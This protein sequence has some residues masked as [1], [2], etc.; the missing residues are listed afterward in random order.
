MPVTIDGTNGISTPG[1]STGGANANLN[2][3]FTSSIDSDGT[4]STG[5][6]TPVLAPSNWKYVLN[7]GAFTIAAPAS[8]GTGVAYT[9]VVYVENVAG[10]GAITLTGFNKTAGDSF[11][12]TVGHTFFIYI[13]VFGGGAKV[14]SVVA[15]Q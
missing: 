11:T 9:M 10:A 13:T 2:G 14:A 1:I 15:S 4:F 6:Y 5:V 12:T 8:L 3:S 7:A